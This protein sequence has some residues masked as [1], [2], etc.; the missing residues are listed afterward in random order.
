MIITL[1][2][3]PVLLDVTSKVDY[4]HHMNN[5]RNKMDNRVTVA[6][7]I[8]QLSAMPQDVFVTLRGSY[9][10]YDGFSHPWVVL[11]EDGQVVVREADEPEGWDGQPDEA[12]EWADFDA[13]C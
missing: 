8:S 2:N 6:D 5:E 7:L 3:D 11:G 12:Q 13:D 10:T 4:N 9:E 1:R